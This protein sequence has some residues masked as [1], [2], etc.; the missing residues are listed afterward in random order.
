M[1]RLLGLALLTVGFG[2]CSSRILLG[3]PHPDAG[4]PAPAAVPTVEVLPS[5]IDFGGVVVNTISPPLFVTLLNPGT[6]PA[7]VTFLPEPQGGPFSTKVS[8]VV[9]PV[10]P[11]M[12]GGAKTASPTTFQPST[13]GPATGILQYQVC[14]AGL[15]DAGCSSPLQSITLMGTGL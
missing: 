12:G 3:N 11:S 7:V 5:P 4:G 2:G 15:A 14:P 13:R 10:L 9:L 6:V 1:S 8:T